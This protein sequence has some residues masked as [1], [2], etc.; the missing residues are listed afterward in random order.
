VSGAEGSPLSSCPRGKRLDRPLHL[1]QR[2]ARARQALPQTQ[3]P[4]PG[5]ESSPHLWDLASGSNWALWVALGSTNSLA[6]LVVCS[7]FVAVVAAGSLW[8]TWAERSCNLPFFMLLPCSCLASH[9]SS[10]R[11]FCGG[12]RGR[13]KTRHRLQETWDQACCTS[14]SPPRILYT[15]LHPQPSIQDTLGAE[16]RCDPPPQVREKNR[17]PSGSLSHLYLICLDG[18]L[19]IFCSLLPE[20]QSHRLWGCSSAL[21]PQPPGCLCGG[22][23]LLARGALFPSP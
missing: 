4:R 16:L 13:E 6:L 18:D 5:L 14:P 1:L 3:H 17:P 19:L 23:C 20:R 10:L 8:V 12:L 21:N 22:F 9:V 15:K 11:G 7:Y 2:D